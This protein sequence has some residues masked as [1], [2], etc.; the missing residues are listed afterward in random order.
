MFRAR[1]MKLASSTVMCESA[2][3]ALSLVSV[4]AWGQSHRSQSR[5]SRIMV[6]DL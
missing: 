5:Y 4:S 2:M 3:S 6:Q 1:V